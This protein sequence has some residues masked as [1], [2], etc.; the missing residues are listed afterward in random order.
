[1]LATLWPSS[2]LLKPWDVQNHIRSCGFG[3]F[4]LFCFVLFFYW[5]F[6]LFTFQMLSPFLVPPLETLYPTLT[7]ASM[8]VFHHHPPTCSS[9]PTLTFPYTGA[10]NLPRTKGL[11]SHWCTPRPFSAGRICWKMQEDHKFEASLGWTR[12]RFSHRVF[13]HGTS[14]LELFEKIRRK[15]T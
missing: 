1:V 15:W 11:T 2:L 8:R 7:P 14:W 10:S 3:G 9:L 5:I 4:V 13:L 6:S 12:N